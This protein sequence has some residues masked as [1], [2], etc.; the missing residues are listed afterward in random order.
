MYY[1]FE[2]NLYLNSPI[3]FNKLNINNNNNNNESISALK[4]LNCNNTYV[5]SIELLKIDNTIFTYIVK[6]KEDLYSLFSKIIQ[7]INFMYFTYYYS[8]HKNNF[9][10]NFL[11][12]ISCN[13]K[14]IH[15]KIEE[16]KIL[17][18]LPNSITT[19]SFTCYNK[20]NN[21][22][23]NFNNLPNKLTSFEIYN[24]NGWIKYEHFNKL[25]YN[26][27]KI[28]TTK[29]SSI[30]GHNNIN[31]FNSYYI[32]IGQKNIHSYKNNKIK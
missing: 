21:Y 7:Y 25:P 19:A 12:I 10:F 11:H 24:S 3:Q 27:D 23:A 15:I 13:L 16:K 14:Q 28:F 1:N 8:Y 30:I 9:S 31:N 6:N 4:I 26:L 29:Y 18:Y 17:K 20:K 22:S 5:N 32:T 2:F